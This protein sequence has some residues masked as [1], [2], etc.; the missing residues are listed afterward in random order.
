MFCTVYRHMPEQPKDHPAHTSC[1]KCRQVLCKALG[2]PVFTLRLC[3][4]VKA[5]QARVYIKVM[6]AEGEHRACSR[7]VTWSSCAAEEGIE[8][9]ADLVRNIEC[10]CGTQGHIQ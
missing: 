3:I 6:T 9:G 7:D 5:G 1:L 8:R 2:V 10:H 4:H